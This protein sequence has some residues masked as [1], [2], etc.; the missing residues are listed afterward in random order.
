MKFRIVILVLALLL[1]AVNYGCADQTPTIRVAHFPNVTHAQAL[2]MKERSTLESSMDGV[3]V[4]WE[5]F[6]AGPSVIEAMF[7]GQIDIAY[8]GPVPAINAFIKS[9]GDIRVIAGAADGGAELLVAKDSGITE[10][11]DLAGKTVAIPQL[12]NTQHLCLLALLQKHDLSPV[13]DGGTVDVIAVSNSDIQGLLDRG[14][15]DAA[16][17][18]EPWA[19]LLERNSGAL[20][21]PFDGN[22]AATTVIIVRK[23]FLDKYPE[24]VEKFLVL[25]SEI[26]ADIGT[27]PDAAKRDINAQI[28]LLTGSLISPEILDSA[29][30]RIVFSDRIP[31]GSLEEYA[32][33]CLSI[34]LIK[35]LPGQELIAELPE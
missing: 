35:S 26:T 8:V 1:A 20:P 7:A 18:P 25:H 31:A 9:K 2:I 19:S 28:E 15:L 17:V 30:S 23:D 32:K 13:S 33:I 29:F 21:I 22:D 16:L 34:G 3:T 27:N 24:L 10:I 14:E 4:D 5:A 11:G 6:N 12:G